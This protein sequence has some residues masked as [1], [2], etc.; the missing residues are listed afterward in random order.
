MHP[1]RRAFLRKSLLLAGATL[2]GPSLLA[3]LPPADEGGNLI[4][5][6]TWLNPPASWSKPGEKILVRSAAKSDFWREPPDDFRDSGHFFHLPVSGDFTF[7]ARI[8]GQYSG[9]YD[10]AGLMVRVDAENWMKCGTEF[11]DSQRHASVVFTR[12]FSDWSTMPDLSQTGPV[13]WRV[14][15]KKNWIESLCSLDGKSFASARQGYFVSAAKADVGIMCAA[16][17]GTGFEASFDDLRLE[18]V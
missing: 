3:E 6:M 7:Q 2:I 1:E 8:N 11:Y 18:I 16:P 9:Q 14:I 13:W 4:A 10:H 17:K 15:R 5:R 12:G